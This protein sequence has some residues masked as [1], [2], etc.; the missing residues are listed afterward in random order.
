MAC[1]WFQVYAFCFSAFSGL[2]FGYDLC[3]ITLALDSIKEHFSLSVEEKEAVVSTLMGGAVVGALVGGSLAD[4]CGR[5]RTIILSAACFTLGSVWL[6]LAPTFIHLILGRIIVGIGVG[7]SGMVASVYMTELAPRRYR[8]ILVSVNEVAVCTGCLVAIGMDILYAHAIQEDP[9][10]W[11]LGTPAVFAT[12]QFFGCFFLPSS[13]RWLI[14]NGKLALAKKIL[15]RIHG[16][17]K[18]EEELREMMEVSV[19]YSRV[20]RLSLFHCPIPF[21]VFFGCFRATDQLGKAKPTSPQRSLMKQFPQAK[22]SFKAILRSPPFLLLIL[23]SLPACS[24]A[25]PRITPFRRMR[26][27]KTRRGWGRPTSLDRRCHPPSRRRGLVAPPSSDSF[28]LPSS[29]SL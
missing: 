27:S 5:K 14:K 15:L 16:A 21:A 18:M 19:T 26:G 24:L 2:L 6:A 23:Q 7:C 20:Q 1:S 17:E 11:M 10:R 3:V 13:P 25:I 9:W 8:G 28:A 12:I 29:E 22:W 4:Y